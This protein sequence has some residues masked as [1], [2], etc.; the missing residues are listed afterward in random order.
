MNPG[1]DIDPAQ[2]IQSGGSIRFLKR[3]EIDLIYGR[4]FYLDAMAAGQWDALVLEDYQAV[5]PLTWRSKAG[6]RYLYQPAFTQ[7]TGIFSRLPTTSSLVDAFLLQLGRHFRFAEIFLNYGNEHPSLQKHINFTLPLKDS[8]ERLSGGYKENLVRNLKKPAVSALDYL[9]EIDFRIALQNYRQE[10][11]TR[12]TGTKGE[13]YRNF[14]KLCLFAQKQG[15]LLTRAVTDRSQQVLASALLFQDAR[16][17]FLLLFTT[18]AEGRR[19]DAGHFLIDRL[20]REWAATDL[21]LDFEGSD[22][23]GVARF[24]GSFGGFDQPYFFYR[25]NQLP[26]PIRWLK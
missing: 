6:I 9:K 5:M 23:P 10:Y 2:A 26:W 17:L 18:L 14:E 24:Y 11:A 19:V 22:H 8:Y 7:Q 25:H 1:N 4:S 13:D 20:V 21:V 3:E 12:N 15:M 16:R